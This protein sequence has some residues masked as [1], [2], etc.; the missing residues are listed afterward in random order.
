MKMLNQIIVYFLLFSLINNLYSQSSGYISYSVSFEYSQKEKKE[1]KSDQIIKYV[2]QEVEN[3]E[4]ILEYNKNESIFYVTE[5][6]ISDKDNRAYV[7]A[8]RKLI[9]DDII[10]TNIK[11]KEKLT[12]MLFLDQNFL[13]SDTLNI[14]WRI[15]K[16]KEKIGSHICYKATAFIEKNDISING[17]KI[18]AWFTPDIPVSFGPKGYAGLPGLILKLKEN[19]FKYTINRLEFFE[20][21]DSKTIEKPSEGKHITFTEYQKQVLKI[22]NQFKFEQ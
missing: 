6:M 15:T 4:C 8:A 13:I 14:Q 19:K 9:G 21:N 16:D 22:I 2:A 11:T 20:K 5:S 1:T 7:K 3:L 17:K 18:E 10:Y 12:K